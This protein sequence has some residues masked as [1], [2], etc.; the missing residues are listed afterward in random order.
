VKKAVKIWI[1]PGFHAAGAAKASPRQ[2]TAGRK[3]K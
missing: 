3:E 1:Y 2:L